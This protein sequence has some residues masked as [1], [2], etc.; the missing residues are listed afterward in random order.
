MFPLLAYSIHIFGSFVKI[1][2]LTTNVVQSTTCDAIRVVTT[3][4]L[5]DINI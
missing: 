2:A 4:R 3:D 1:N 5:E